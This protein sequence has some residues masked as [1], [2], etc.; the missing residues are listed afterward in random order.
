[1]RVIESQH[2]RERDRREAR[3]HWQSVVDKYE[4]G[5][6]RAELDS[7]ADDIDEL[8]NSQV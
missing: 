6:L 7:L 5:L 4:D 8:A 2:Q 1:M 3:T